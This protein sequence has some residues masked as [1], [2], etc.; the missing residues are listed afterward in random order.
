MKQIMVWVEWRA[1]M[2]FDHPTGFDSHKF[3]A[4]N[5]GVLIGARGSAGRG[6]TGHG[7]TGLI[8]KVSRAQVWRDIY[9]IAVRGSNNYSDFE[10]IDLSNAIDAVKDPAIR[11]EL[12]QDPG[13][14]AKLDCLD[15]FD[16]ANLVGD[17]AVQ[18]TAVRWTSIERRAVLSDGR[19]Q[20]GQLRCAGLV[21]PYVC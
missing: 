7:G 3:R 20:R 6:T 8:L 9:Y 21:W 4:R 1:R 18:Q 12:R 11:S 16:A 14:G 5:R 15:L 2:N 13:W 17:K 10:R 19:Q